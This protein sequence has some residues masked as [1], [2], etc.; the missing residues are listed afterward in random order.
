MS[1]S[2]TGSPN[3]RGGVPPLPSLSV[4]CL[5]HLVTAVAVRGFPS[6]RLPLFPSRGGQAALEL[7]WTSGIGST[8]V[9]RAA[10][11]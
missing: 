4:V 11:E 7:L 6:A 8:P 10:G 2:C 1:R 9:A 5:L 3:H